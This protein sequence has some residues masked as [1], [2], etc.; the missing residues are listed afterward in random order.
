MIGHIDGNALA[1]PLA[2]VFRGD[3]TVVRAE[4]AVCADV[5]P[6]AAGMLY[7]S[8]MGFV[9]RCR[10]CDNVLLVVAR[11]GSDMSLAVP[12]ITSMRYHGAA[13]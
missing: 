8:D 9:L 7:R 1:G 6:I 3:F 11:R 5:A 12:G 10:S 13:M 4:C 2:G